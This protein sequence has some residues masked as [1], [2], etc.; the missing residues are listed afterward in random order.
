M[1]DLYSDNYKT[2]MRESEDDTN[3]W[4]DIPCSSTEKT[5]M[6]KMSTLPKAN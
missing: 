5:N 2:T 3:K 4:K 1:K 6:V